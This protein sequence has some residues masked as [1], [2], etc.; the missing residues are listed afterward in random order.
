MC[1]IITY[2]LYLLVY[3]ILFPYPPHTLLEF[4]SL[5]NL[6]FTVLD[7]TKP[8]S[9]LLY[10]SVIPL[11]SCT[12]NN[13]SSV[14]AISTGTV[15]CWLFILFFCCPDMA[16]AQVLSYLIV[17]SAEK[18]SVYESQ[19]NLKRRRYSAS[20]CVCALTRRRKL[21]RGT[22]G[23]KL[24]ELKGDPPSCRSLCFVLSAD[25][26]LTINKAHTTMKFCQ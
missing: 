24:R 2:L 20:A 14:I 25:C 8:L 6:Y 7:Y 26:A 5:Y 15:Y 17:K 12:Q 18:I 1:N 21:A 19:N 13:P 22:A 11:R 10:W 23:L 9:Y 16:K 3:F 4:L